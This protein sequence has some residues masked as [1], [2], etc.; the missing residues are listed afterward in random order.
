MEHT[1]QIIVGH[2][3]LIYEGDDEQHAAAVFYNLMLRE[4][5]SHNPRPMLMLEHGVVVTAFEGRDYVQC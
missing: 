4:Q 3:G 2:L 5:T 1:Y